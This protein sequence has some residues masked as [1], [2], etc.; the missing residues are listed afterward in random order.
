[1]IAQSA[2]TAISVIFDIIILIVVPSSRRPVTV[3]DWG[4]QNTGESLWWAPVYLLNVYLG[5]RSWRFGEKGSLVSFLIVNIIQLGLTVWELTPSALA[6]WMGQIEKT[7]LP[8]GEAPRIWDTL[9]AL[10]AI[11]VIS[12]IAH[13]IFSIWGIVASSRVR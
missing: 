7:W 9:I 12:A 10:H 3:T 4:R 1:M 5:F 11:I 6:I 13:F 8:E 2:S